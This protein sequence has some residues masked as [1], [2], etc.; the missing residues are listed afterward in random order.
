M[1]KAIVDAQTRLTEIDANIEALTVMVQCSDGESRCL[2]CIAAELSFHVLQ[3]V[4]TGW[5]P[6]MVFGTRTCHHRE[7]PSLCVRNAYGFCD[8][9]PNGRCP[10]VHLPEFNGPAMAAWY[11]FLS[12]EVLA[13]H[14]IEVAA[15]VARRV[16]VVPPSAA[17]KGKKAKEFQ[18]AF[19]PLESYT[20]EELEAIEA[21]RAAFRALLPPPSA[22]V[23]VVVVVDPLAD[24]TLQ[25]WKTNE[26]A[27]SFSRPA[28]PDKFI[29]DARK[30]F[31]RYA[32]C[33]TI[34]RAVAAKSFKGK[35]DLVEETVHSF[36]D[37]CLDFWA[38]FYGVP[39]TNDFRVVGQKDNALFAK[40]SGVAANC[41][42]F[43]A[44][45]L[46][47]GVNQ[48]KGE[49]STTFYSWLRSNSNYPRAIDLIG[50]RYELLESAISYCAETGAAVTREG[51]EAFITPVAVE[52]PA[53]QEVK[54]DFDERHEVVHDDTVDEAVVEAAHKAATHRKLL[55]G[56]V[57]VAP[58]T[59]VSKAD[60]KAAKAATKAA[61]TA[62]KAP[63]AEEVDT[64][65]ANPDHADTSIDFVC[66][67]FPKRTAG[68]VCE[69]GLAGSATYHPVNFG[70]FTK[71]DAKA[72]QAA[73][74][75]CVKGLRSKVQLRSAKIVSVWDDEEEE[76][77]ENGLF[78]VVQFACPSREVSQ[79]EASR[80]TRDELDAKVVSNAVE[81]SQLLSTLAL[82]LCA[83]PAISRQ[84]RDF[85]V[86]VLNVYQRKQV[87]AQDEK[88]CDH[89]HKCQCS[90]NK[91]VAFDIPSSKSTTS[92]KEV[93]LADGS[94][95]EVSVTTSEFYDGEAEDSDD[96]EDESESEEDE[97]ESEEED[98]DDEFDFEDI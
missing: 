89:K 2:D 44:Q 1:Q 50:A 48:S 55:L 62:P 41:P 40:L 85:T 37:D 60:A 86:T 7:Q 92:L 95:V 35:A 84:G 81:T 94:V 28:N 63:K 69:R 19:K 88:K 82:A 30:A 57:A 80:M 13:H 97:S 39:L 78:W 33:R 74:N 58:K 38:F 9:K 45:Y 68:S 49:V 98:D 56:M 91:L 72:V 24:F 75:T 15:P 34:T 90:K 42:K 47:V 52:K 3:D 51:F 96:E 17:A 59:K 43:F 6:V 46:K 5:E 20:P 76:A 12:A 10:R 53:S 26:L 61:K 77:D 70:P 16:Q 71:S 64:Y 83:T 29:R 8:G 36:R 54:E 11:P 73:Y 14:R 23:E 25:M 79:S 31:E 27:Q 21:E 93:T 65:V 4:T 66:L 32:T 18:E 67:P 22:A 87:F